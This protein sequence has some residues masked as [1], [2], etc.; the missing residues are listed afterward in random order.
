MQTLNLELEN[1]CT[2]SD[3]R[4]D[5]M[6]SHAKQLQVSN[7]FNCFWIVYPLICLTLH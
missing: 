5:G 2:M 3:N 1:K 7:V 6:Q 4:Y